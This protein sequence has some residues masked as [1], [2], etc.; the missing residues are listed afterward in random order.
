M[1]YVASIKLG[2]RI[3]C[4]ID[5]TVKSWKD[6][7]IWWCP[8]VHGVSIS[9]RS[10]RTRMFQSTLWGK[11]LPSGLW[12]FRHHHHKSDPMPWYKWTFWVSSHIFH[13]TADQIF[14]M[15]TLS[16]IFTVGC[17]YTQLQPPWPGKLPCGK[18]LQ[19]VSLQDNTFTDAT[20]KPYSSLSR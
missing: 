8:T 17:L 2:F 15:P 9:I 5:A 10:Q 3:N 13:N 11:M 19:T 1:S 4:R 20:N 12:S 6:W 14:G 18:L 16:S 7:W